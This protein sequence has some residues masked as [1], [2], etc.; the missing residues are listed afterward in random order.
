[1]DKPKILL[2][3]S[4]GRSSAMM[5]DLVLHSDWHKHCEILIVCANTGWEHDESLI[6]GKHCADRWA[7]LGYEVVWVESVVQEGRQSS[8]FK[9]VDF[10]SA[11][12]KQQPFI[13]VIQKY[14]IANKGYPHCTR[15]LKN[16]PIHKYVWSRGWKKGEYL[17]CIGMRSDEPKRLTYTVDKQLLQKKCYPLHEWFGGRTKQDVL[18]YWKDWEYDLKIPEHMGNCLGCWQKCDSKLKTV[19]REKPESFVFPIEMEAHYGHIGKNKIRGEYSDEPRRFFRGEQSAL[20]MV[21]K[22]ENGESLEKKNG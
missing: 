15:E 13:D 16:M 19:Y 21:T 11:N 18:N 12:R 6:F 14:G 4:M 8:T 20:D 17:T 3:F 1:M 2:T 7:S 10:W 22:Y 9:V 5:V